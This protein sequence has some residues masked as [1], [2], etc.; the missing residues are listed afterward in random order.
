MNSPKAI[1]DDRRLVVEI[2]EK[3]GELLLDWSGR[4][5]RSDVGSKSAARDLVTA[6]D[7]ASEEFI[8]NSLSEAFPGDSFMA[9]ESATETQASQGTVWCVDPLDG[10]VNF[11][12]GLPMYAVS[13]ARLVD[14]VANLAVVHL[15]RLGET[16]YARRGGGAWLGSRQ[17][18]VSNASEPVKSL[19]ATG[20]PYRRH[21]LADNNL[22]NFQRMF[23]NQQGIRRMG[24]AATD[25]AYVA[26]GRLD[27]FW[28]LHL[29]PWDVAAG[30]LLVQE[31]GG[32]V[33]TIVPGGDFL[34]GGNLIAGPPQLVEGMRTL[35]LEGRSANYPDLGD[36]P[37]EA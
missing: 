16:F 9:E 35:L 33:D 3:A 24:A 7:L 25:L 19:L 26:A 30:A 32:V 5:A 15:P 21:L 27:G 12:H 23:L 29:S 28:E 2:A 14:G 31:A 34:F 6:A 1:H 20:F 11:V 36:R 18:S 17:I 10:T 4:L 13:I 37:L 8:L 22:E